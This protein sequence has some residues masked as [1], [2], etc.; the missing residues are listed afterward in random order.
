MTQESKAIPE[1]IFQTACGIV[2]E[3]KSIKSMLKHKDVVDAI[4]AALTK[5]R[6]RNAQ[7]RKLIIEAMC[8]LPH[9]ID[10]DRV[11]FRFNPKR[12]GNNA[13]NQLITALEGQFGSAGEDL[14]ASST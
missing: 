7:P 6:E 3:A 10:D 2:M 14:A 4:A 12:P 8:D 13:L 1:D 9:T 11:Q 5:E